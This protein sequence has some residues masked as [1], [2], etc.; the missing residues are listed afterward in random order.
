MPTRKKSVDPE[1][2]KNIEAL[3]AQLIAAVENGKLTEVIELLQAGANPDCFKAPDGWY[4]D[5]QRTP[6]TAACLLGHVKIAEA[7]VE[8]GAHINRK[9]KHVNLQGEDASATPLMAACDADEKLH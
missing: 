6:L 5:N 4:P 9:D 3:N 7:L 8:A 1:R 2:Q